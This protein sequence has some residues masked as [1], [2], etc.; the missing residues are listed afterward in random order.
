MTTTELIV[1]KDHLANSRLR[2][3]APDD[4]VANNGYF[5]AAPPPVLQRHVGPE[6]VHDAYRR[7]LAGTTDPRASPMLSLCPSP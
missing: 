5:G 4:F 1:R 7:L 3:S 2:D 6:A